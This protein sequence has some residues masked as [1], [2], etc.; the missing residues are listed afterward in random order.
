MVACHWFIGYQYSQCNSKPYHNHYLYRNSNGQQWLLI[1]SRH[2]HYLKHNASNCFG[3]LNKHLC[4]QLK[5]YGYCN[6]KWW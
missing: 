4:G 5:R 1:N 6:S 2:N 3:Y